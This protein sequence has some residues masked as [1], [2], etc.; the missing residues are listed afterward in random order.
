[1]DIAFLAIYGDSLM[2]GRVITLQQKQ[3]PRNKQGLVL[4]Q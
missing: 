3:Q 2:T 1:M 4:N